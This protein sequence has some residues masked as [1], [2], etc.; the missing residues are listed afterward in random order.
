MIA[1]CNYIESY[2]KNITVKKENN[3]VAQTTYT[4][5]F[6]TMFLVTIFVMLLCLDTY[7]KDRYS[8]GL[9]KERFPLS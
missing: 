9:F 5:S 2:S 1:K 4:V 8:T 6:M 7:Y 3:V